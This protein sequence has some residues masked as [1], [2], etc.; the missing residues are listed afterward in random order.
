MD[1]LVHALLKH[2]LE[3]RRV[4]SP[5]A[6]TRLVNVLAA[7]AAAAHV[8]MAGSGDAAA[9]KKSASMAELSAS[10]AT[11]SSLSGRPGKPALQRC[12][13]QQHQ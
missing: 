1:G 12:W 13:P 2:Q 9:D 11:F 7:Q 3:R 6:A 10:N 5:G 8:V 4:G